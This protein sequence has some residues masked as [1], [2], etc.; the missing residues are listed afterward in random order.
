MVVQ[1]MVHRN[2]ERRNGHWARH[3]QQRDDPV[4]DIR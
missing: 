4:F 2:N 1:V 3:E